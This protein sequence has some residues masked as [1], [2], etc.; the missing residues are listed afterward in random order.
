MTPTEFPRRLATLLLRFAIW[1]APRDTHDWG[2]GMLSELHHVEGNWSAL[3]W[4]LGGAGV[5]AK[6][7]ML[8]LI[9]PGDHRRTVSS[10]SELF[11][12]EGPMRK[13][14]F[15]V[16]ACCVLA[17][18]FFFFVPV[19]R[20]AFQVS[21]SQ[22][23]AV[24][25]VQR[26]LGYRTPD[27]ELDALAKKAEQHH[28]AEALAFVA[29]REPNQSEAVRLADEAVR[30]DARLTWLYAIV[31]V[32]WS[33]FPEL[34]R[35]VPALE[36][37]DPQNAL[38]H[39][40]TAERIDIDQVVRRQV[41]RRMAEESAAWKDA[42]SAAFG[43]HKLDDY[44][45]RLKQLD[46]RV[47]VGHGIS[48]PFEA[49]SD[50][51]YRLP[52]YGI[53]DSSRYAE[54]LIE[55]GDSMEARSDHRAAAEK[56][57]VVVSFGQLLTPTDSFFLGREIKGAYKRLGALSEMDGNKAEAA[58]YVSLTDQVDRESKREQASWRSRFA[59][60]KV[61]HWDAFL[62]RL[63]GLLMLLCGGMLVICAAGVTLRSRSVRL[64]SLRPSRLTLTLG[65]GAALG[66]LLASAV[67][68]VSYWPYSQILHR[69]ISDSDESGVSELSNFLGDAQVP[70][71]TRGYLSVSNA[72]FYF[73]FIVA[74]LCALALLVAVVR[75]FQTR[76]RP[77][78]A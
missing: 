49:I 59:G 58:F 71:G 24:F 37:F 20:Q 26:S 40:I 15:A 50:R 72:V 23:R 56:Y 75:H 9:L 13:T 32:Q 52:S 54:W 38:P 39:L 11:D 1:I 18:L 47:L 36:K 30:L 34:D 7:A 3:L 69:F 2:H 28:D 57:L 51:G 53:S 60:S 35:W 29:V 64:A 31:A 73:W 61:S 70:L 25:H 62:V 5:L 66:S 19:F 63:A 76:T 55:S 67:L 27:P 46:R 17:S 41:P 45:D 4:S 42:M 43:S 68:L 6:H 78:A 48:N 22:W 33:S 16:I 77:H 44:L 14:T 12:K 8:A 74:V 65:F 21:L 10:A